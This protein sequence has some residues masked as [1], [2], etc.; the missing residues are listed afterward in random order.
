MWTLFTTDC[1]SGRIVAGNEEIVLNHRYCI[2]KIYLVTE[3]SV[4]TWDQLGN[5]AYISRSS[6]RVWIE[7]QHKPEPTTEPSRRQWR[8]ASLSDWYTATIYVMRF[9]LHA[10]LLCRTKHGMIL[11]QN[12]RSGISRHRFPVKCCIH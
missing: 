1:S 8:T 4:E 10:R 9:L 7:Y 3:H 12:K 6:I 2:I 5:S 11:A